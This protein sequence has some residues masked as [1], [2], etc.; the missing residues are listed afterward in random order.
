MDNV[1][2][3][4]VMRPTKKDDLKLGNPWEIIPIKNNKS[5]KECTEIHLA[6]QNID[7][8]IGF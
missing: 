1:F 2:K 7:N 4:L 3:N 6:N 5:A 8:L